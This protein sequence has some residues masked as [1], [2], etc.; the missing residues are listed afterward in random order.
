MFMLIALV[1]L[2]S[3]LAGLAGGWYLRHIE[4]L[5]PQCGDVLTCAAC[6]RRPAWSSLDRG[7]PPTA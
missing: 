6:R 4:K 3:L 1:A 2:G 7:R 5:C